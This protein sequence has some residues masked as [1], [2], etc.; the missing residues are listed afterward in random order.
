MY[1]KQTEY[2]TNIGKIICKIACDSQLQTTVKKN[3]NNHI[4]AERC[5]DFC[6]FTVDL[7]KAV[8]KK[9]I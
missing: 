7:S 3:P 9:R 4:Y 6:M 2:K 5:V 8:S 1:I